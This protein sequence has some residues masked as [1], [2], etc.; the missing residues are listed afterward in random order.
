MKK[1]RLN[2][3]VGSR[4]YLRK[5]EDNKKSKVWVLEPDSYYIRVGNTSEGHKFIDPPGGPFLAV[6]DTVEEIGS[7]IKSIEFIEG[8][9]WCITFE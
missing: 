2:S 8:Y 7:V 1:I 5:L 9:G 6:G 4:N 3:R